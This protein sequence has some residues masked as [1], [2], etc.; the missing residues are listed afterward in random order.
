LD[1]HSASSLKQQPTWT[2]YPDYVLTHYPD[3]VLTHYPDYVLTHY[4]DYVLTHYPDYV[5][6]NL[7]YYCFMMLCEEA[8]DTQ[9]ESTVYK[10]RYFF[11][12]GGFVPPPFP[13]HTN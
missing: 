6:T 5:L 7:C 11:H 2:H 1:F 3:Y 13:F 8:A 9:Q 10:I 4:P 12:I